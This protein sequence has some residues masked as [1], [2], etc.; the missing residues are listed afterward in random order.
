MQMGSVARFTLSYY[1]LPILSGILIGTSYIPFPPWALFFCLTPL[2]LFWHRL[3]S[4]DAPTDTPT[5]A[6]GATSTEASTGTPA[7]TASGSTASGRRAFI[8]GWITQFLLNAIGFH[9]ISYTA[10]EFGHFPWW[11]GWLTLLGFCAIAHLY[12][13]VAG[14]IAFHLIRKVKLAG[15]FAILTAATVFALCDHRFPMI[16]PWHLGYPWL[17]ANWPGAQFADTVGFEG[18][19]IITIYVNALFAWAITARSEP[20][21]AVTIAAGAMALALAPNLV[22]LGRSEKWK[23][24]DAEI[25]IVAVQGNIGNFD[26]LMAEKGPHFRGPIIQKFIGLSR[27]ILDA[28]ILDDKSKA[29]LMIWPETA[30]P[31]YL[32]APFFGETNA[33]DVRSFVSAAGVPLLTGSY[34]YDV[35][36]KQA[37]NGLFFIDAKGEQPVAPYRKSILLIFGETF[38]F[39]DYLPYMD[40]L[41]PG[42]GSFGRGEGPSVMNISYLRIGPQICYE[43]LYPWFSAELARAGAQMFVNVTNDSWFGANDSWKGAYFEPR[44]HLY[45][46]L[47]R[48]IEF[49][50][51]LMRSTNTGITTAILAS[52]EILQASPIGKE[53]TGLFKIPYMTDPPHTLYEKIA[54]RWVWALAFVL[55][56]LLIFGRERSQRNHHRDGS[57]RT[58]KP[59][60]VGLAGNSRAP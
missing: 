48:A 31:D 21:K 56:L 3:A 16:F 33:V 26:K 24:T 10:I 30:Y 47:A 45:M 23:K 8:G 40:K 34:S 32:D 20:R 41:F 49:R 37:F 9:W 29:Q 1:R 58:R 54:G 55:I 12:Y 11:G 7:G 19:N 2:F 22:G 28:Q 25:N 4:T 43:G 14:W 51:P 42:L 53:W 6:P 36:T 50:R 18:L 52:G 39:S 17:W 35:K 44:Q 27:Q 59:E 46:T 57:H 38:P 13:P 5:N 60:S 15:G